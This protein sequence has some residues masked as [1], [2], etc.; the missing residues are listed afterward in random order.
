MDRVEIEKIREPIEQLREQISCLDASMAVDI[1]T[2]S[3]LKKEEICNLL[4]QIAKYKQ[5]IEQLEAAVDDTLGID[6][7]R[8]TDFLNARAC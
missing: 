3:V 7:K 5:L 1:L 2:K 8:I 4:V 6:V